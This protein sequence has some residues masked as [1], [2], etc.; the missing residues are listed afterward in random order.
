[1]AAPARYPIYQTVMGRPIP[2]TEACL[3][4]GAIKRLRPTAWAATFWLRR[5][6]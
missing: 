6:A 4:K 5:R 2:S 1:L 3:R